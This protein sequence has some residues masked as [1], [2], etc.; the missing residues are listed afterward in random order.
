MSLKIKE[1][2]KKA[3]ESFGKEKKKKVKEEK[4]E[5]EEEKKQ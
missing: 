5:E 3:N 4:K 2:E 1:L